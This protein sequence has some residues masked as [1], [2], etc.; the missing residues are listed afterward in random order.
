MLNKHKREYV[1]CMAVPKRITG[2]AGW[3]KQVVSSIERR[4][5]GFKLQ[6]A[7]PRHI[8]DLKTRGQKIGL[9]SY[10]VPRIKRIRCPDCGQKLTVRM[11]D[12]EPFSYS[13]DY[14]PFY[15]AHKKPVKVKPSK[16][17]KKNRKK[18]YKAGIR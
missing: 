10:V 8:A 1:W 16:P 9:Y 5:H 7:F 2:T 13:G 11:I 12:V 14:V 15:P 17:T 18:G 3:C 4:P 6:S